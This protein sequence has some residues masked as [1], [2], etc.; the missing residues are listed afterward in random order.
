MET[1]LQESPL[2]ESMEDSFAQWTR[3]GSDDMEET[4]D[5]ARVRAGNALL[6]NPMF[7]RHG[8]LK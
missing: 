7:L 4:P 1:P 8:R 3:L 5:A 2:Q 6:R